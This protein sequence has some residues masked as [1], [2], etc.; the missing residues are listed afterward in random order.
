[1][2]AAQ[3]REE[4]GEKKGERGE[5]ERGREGGRG[6]DMEPRMPGGAARGTYVPE[7][8]QVVVG[9][10]EFLEGDELPHPVRPGGW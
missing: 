2:R 7:R 10:L 1:M 6:E 8:V 9:E 4:L 3:T 5:R